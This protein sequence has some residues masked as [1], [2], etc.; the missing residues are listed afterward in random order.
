[1]TVSDLP[2]DRRMAGTRLA[3]LL[4]AWQHA[5]PAYTALA[6][7]LRA[8]VLSG[9]L[10]LSTRLPGERELADALG[11]SRTTATAA[12]GLLRDEGYLVSRR[13]S[14]TV[15]TLPTA[16]GA[17]TPTPV[18]PGSDDSLAD[19]SVAAPSAPS[20]LHA[21]YLAALDALPRHLA[22]TGYS[23]L[24]LP[25]LRDA[26]ARWYTR[27]GA[28]TTPDQ[29]LVTTGA[30]QAIH[31]LV[32]AHA[33]PGDRVVVEQP[34]YPHAMDVVRAAGARPV[35]VPSGADGLD[36]DLL[37]ST[38]RQ[39]APRLVYLIPDHRNPTGTS[40]DPAQREQ[41]RA[42]ARRYRT[43][44]VGDEVL[45][46]LTLD[47]P[48]PELY[49]GDGTA[50]HVVVTIGSAS[51][52][53]WGGLRV[54]WVRAHPDLVGRL[55]S[56]RAHVDIGTAPM[57]QLVVAELIERADDVL[58]ARRRVLRE[59]RDLLVGLLRDQLPA[60]DVPVPAGGL[61]LWVDLGAP[62]SS[63]LA[64][65]AVRHGVRVVP[66][67]AFGVDTALEDHLRLPFAEE[68][69]VLR[70]GVLG[71][72]AAWQDLGSATWEPVAPVRAVV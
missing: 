33:G 30:Q 4:G 23:P 5:G 52:S 50:A 70:R 6:D 65:S 35:P 63:A 10:P 43:T 67:P 1:M 45:R 56:V 38:L 53:F 58:A 60:W 72:A 7:A 2:T 27:R 68:P 59:R 13:G 62:V 64:A 57:E 16:P 14:G 28:P 31:L 51:K 40:L 18:P 8:A 37:E 66:G 20:A 25:V 61:S 17:R 24:G 54:G 3:R 34:T 47:G 41:V 42:L 22:G 46:E 15:T 19:L 26:L 69:D 36:V 39:V 12:Y 49:A 55:A 71:L 9:T 21:A 32:A 48:A 11:I 44:V 29:I